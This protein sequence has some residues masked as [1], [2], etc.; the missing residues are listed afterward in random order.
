MVYP[1]TNLKGEADISTPVY[2]IVQSFIFYDHQIIK[3]PIA[4][5]IDSGA[6]CCYCNMIIGEYLKINFKNKK[7]ITSTAANGSKFKGYFEQLTF[8]VS[9]RRF[10]TDVIFC[11]DMNPNFP[12]IFGQTGFFSNF[13]VCFNKSRNEFSLT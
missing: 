7:S 4:G 9:G 13:Q 8:L 5:L 12:L 1:Y 11:R 3:T 6:Q 2:P 10:T